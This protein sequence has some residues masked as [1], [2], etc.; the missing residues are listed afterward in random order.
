MTTKCFSF[1]LT[2]L[3]DSITMCGYESV[4]YNL[5][6]DMKVKYFSSI[7]TVLHPLIELENTLKAVVRRGCRGMTHSVWKWVST[8]TSLSS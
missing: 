5:I 2:T 1:Q 7:T 3:I 6:S 4:Y 8:I